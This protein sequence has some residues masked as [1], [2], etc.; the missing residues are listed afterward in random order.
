MPPVWLAKMKKYKIHQV[1]V[2]YSNFHV[3]L[4]GVKT[5]IGTLENCLAVSK[6]NIHTPQ[7]QAISLIGIY[8]TEMQAPPTKRHAQLYRNIDRSI[9]NRYKLQIT[10]PSPIEMDT[11]LHI[12]TMNY[13]IAMK[14]NKP[15]LRARTWTTL[16]NTK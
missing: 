2:N 1:F 6:L 9:Y 5:R 15:Q 7:D 14:M 8:V 10:M 11:F 13:Q 16:T 3:L 12:N 4:V